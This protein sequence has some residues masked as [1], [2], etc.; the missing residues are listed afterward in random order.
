MD[1]LR[2]IARLGRG[3][4][5][6]IYRS[7]CRVVALLLLATTM[8]STTGRAEED[9]TSS[10]DKAQRAHARSMSDVMYQQEDF[11]AL[12]Y[13]NETMIQLLKEIRDEMHA[14]NVRGAN[15]GKK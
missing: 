15:E 7:D 4:S 3:R 14:M 1:F 11:R 12:Y 9:Y 8:L 5:N 2:N 6:L 13:Q 10:E